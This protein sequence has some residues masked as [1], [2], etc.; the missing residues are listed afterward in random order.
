MI[1]LR[2]LT[3]LHTIS[4]YLNSYSC[5]LSPSTVTWFD[6]YLS[7]RCH[8]PCVVNSYSPSGFLS[9][10]VPQGSVLGPTLYLAFIN[11]LPTLRP[12]NSTVLFVDH[13]TIFIINNAIS[14]LQ[15]S[16]Q[17]YLDSA[18]LWLQR[19]GLKLN[20]PAKPTE[21]STTQAGRR[22]FLHASTPSASLPQTL[23][24]SHL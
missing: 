20:T 16:L 19:N 9:S 5:V 4:S 13:A 2:L 15:S 17:H 7:D 8:V 21:C 11:D 22:W 10:G 14:T 24:T 3:Q 6:S 23:H 18:H 12:P 1:D